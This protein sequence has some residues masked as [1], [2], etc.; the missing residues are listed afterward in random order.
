MFHVKHRA[1]SAIREP[2]KIGDLRKNVSR[3]TSAAGPR[4]GESAKQPYG[5][6]N[7]P[8]GTRAWL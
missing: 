3:E 5:S 4:I 2:E 6:K 1:D 8:Y 7:R